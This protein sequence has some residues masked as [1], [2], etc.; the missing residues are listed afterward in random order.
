MELHRFALVDYQVAASIG[1]IFKALLVVAI[2][3]SIKLPIDG[4][5]IVSGAVGAIFAELDGKPMLGA[6]VK[7]GLKAVDNFLSAPMQ[8]ANR[9]QRF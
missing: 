2:T 4:L 5:W 1:F 3:A 6:T 8:V 9:H 7:S